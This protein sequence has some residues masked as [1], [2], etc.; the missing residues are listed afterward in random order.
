[1]HNLQIQ[2]ELS[3]QSWTTW[4]CKDKTGSH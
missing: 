2:Q 1:M 4:S 3:L